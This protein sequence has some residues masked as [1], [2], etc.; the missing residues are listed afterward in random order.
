[1]RFSSPLDI[2]ELAVLLKKSSYSESFDVA[3]T[4]AGVSTSASLSCCFLFLVSSSCAWSETPLEEKIWK[5]YPVR[6]MDSC[7]DVMKIRRLIQKDNPQDVKKAKRLQ[8]YFLNHARP[9]YYCCK[10]CM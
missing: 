3:G 6:L 8:V 2:S 7:P 9:V 4:F 10:N 5:L 1:M